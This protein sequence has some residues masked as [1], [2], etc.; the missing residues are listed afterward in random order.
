MAEGKEDESVR[1]HKVYPEKL[2]L[3]ILNCLWLNLNCF[4]FN[5]TQLNDPREKS[6][7]SRPIPHLILEVS[8]PTLTFI[9]LGII[10]SKD[11]YHQYFIK[12]SIK[13]LNLLS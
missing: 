1:A 3:R 4:S 13:F 12:I 5:F 11:Y 9:F 10:S 6:S 7:Q 8:L 2:L